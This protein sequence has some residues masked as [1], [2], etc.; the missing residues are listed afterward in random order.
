LYLCCPDQQE[1]TNAAQL[2]CQAKKNAGHTVFL[3]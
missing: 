2:A 3:S 1:L